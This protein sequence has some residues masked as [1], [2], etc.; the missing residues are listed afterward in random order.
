MNYAI[1]CFAAKAGHKLGNYRLNKMVKMY[2]TGNKRKFDREMTFWY[3]MFD[4]AGR[5][6]CG[7]ISLFIHNAAA[8]AT[9]R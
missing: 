7:P 4:V 3:K 5:C 2:E 1:Y 6:P 8:E 9:Q